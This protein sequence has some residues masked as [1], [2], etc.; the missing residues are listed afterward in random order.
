VQIRIRAMITARLFDAQE[1]SFVFI[2]QEV[3][4]TIRALPLFVNTL[5]QFP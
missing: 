3:Q 4:Q 2:S 5:S 1:C